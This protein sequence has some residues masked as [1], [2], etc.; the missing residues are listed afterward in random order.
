MCSV[1]ISIR[2][3]W[4]CHK[5]GFDHKN[6]DPQLHQHEKKCYIKLLINVKY[7]NEKHQNSIKKKTEKILCEKKW[8]VSLWLGYRITGW[9]RGTEVKRPI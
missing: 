9:K 3:Y 7:P 6:I 4:K 8:F 2:L 5:L 1:F